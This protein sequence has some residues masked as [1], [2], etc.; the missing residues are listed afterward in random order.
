MIHCVSCTLL[1]CGLYVFVFGNEM[2]IILFLFNR[3]Y[4]LFFLI[5]CTEERRV[6]MENPWLF[7]AE[8][9]KQDL[10]SAF[11]RVKI[12]MEDNDFVQVK[13]VLVARFGRVLFHGLV[14]L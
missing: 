11:H 8:N 2:S 13:P 9:V 14:K 10:L 3:G 7:V 5:E 4:F 12:E 1:H 6:F